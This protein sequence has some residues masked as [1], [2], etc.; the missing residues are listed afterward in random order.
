MRRRIVVFV[1]LFDEIIEVREHRI[2]LW[3]ELCEIRVVR[4]VKLGIQF[5]E[6]YLYRVCLRIGEVFIRAEEVPQKREVLGQH[7]FLFERLRR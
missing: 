4:N 3:L 6:Q 5:R 7:G 1:L 2:I